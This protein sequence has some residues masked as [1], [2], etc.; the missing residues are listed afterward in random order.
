MKRLI[1]IHEAI[2]YISDAWNSMKP[3]TIANCWRHTGLMQ[4]EAEE[5][6]PEDLTPSLTAQIPIEH[7]MSTLWL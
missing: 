2:A 6:Q 7:P 3:Q 1:N 5:L 4:G